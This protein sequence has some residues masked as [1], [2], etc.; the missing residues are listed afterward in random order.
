MGMPVPMMNIIN[1]GAHANN[2][3]DM[4]EFMIIPIGA[5]VS[6]KRCVAGRKYSTR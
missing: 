6:E 2:N 1:G 4:Q 3:I 5:A